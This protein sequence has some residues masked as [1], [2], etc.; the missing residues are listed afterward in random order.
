M[1]NIYQAV[2]P[3]ELTDIARYILTEQEQQE[4]L[5]SQDNQR[6]TS[7]L[8]WF[9]TEF[10]DAVKVSWKADLDTPYDPMVPFRAFDTPVP[11]LSTPGTK[12]KEAS[13]IPLGGGFTE[14]ELQML[15]QRISDGDNER[16][17]M[18]QSSDNKIRIGVNG[19][20]NRLA[21]LTAD[22]IVGGSVALDENGIV[23]TVSID[24][25]AGN[26]ITAATAWS[27]TANADPHDDELGLYDVLENDWGLSWEDLVVVMNRAEFN[28]YR[29]ITAVAN[30]LNTNRVL[31]GRPSRGEV[32]EL[33]AGRDLP[34]ILIMN[35]SLKDVTGTT[36]KLVPNGNAIIMPRPGIQIGEVTWGSPGALSLEG[37][38]IAR[39]ERAGPV[40]L[41]ET[42]GTVPPRRRL[43]VDA[44]GFG[45]V[46]APNWTAKITTNSGI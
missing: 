14:G 41:I 38:D 2:P 11:E 16:E 25:D 30:E 13:M 29:T 7:F 43:V 17:V 31:S 39:S 36:R 24:R 10:K 15:L 45:F 6:V 18:L 46:Q 42:N 40:A 28:H 4:L 37:V 33:R 32:N 22:M 1:S 35:R 8:P 23:E 3:S 21:L 27:D 20:R 19:S 12:T 26:E 9:R 5:D 44:I 34:P